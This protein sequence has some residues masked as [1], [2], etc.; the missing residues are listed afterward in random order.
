MARLI[1]VHG[2]FCSSSV[3]GSRVV[4]ELENL[5]HDVEILDLPSH[6]RDATPKSDVT[7]DLY[8]DAVTNHV[9]SKPEP[10]VLVGHSM[11]GLVIT[12]AADN[13][14]AAGGE[15]AGLIY[16]AAALPR[17]GKAQNDYTSLPE[18]AG[19]ELGGNLVLSDTKPTLATVPVEL[20]PR[21]LFND[22]P[23][24]VGLELGLTLE[25]QTVRVF[26]SPVHITDDRPIH[27]GYILCTNDRAIPP[28]LQRLM[29]TETPGV[30]IIELESD[31]SPFVSHPD[32]FLAAVGELLPK[33]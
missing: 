1:L 3:W 28:A 20:A 6:G 2:A 23:E 21:A 4:H 15:I 13:V 24:Q 31:H 32:E 7:L 26:F 29:A 18:G 25:S 8:A 33:D 16:V 22:L 12:Q 11:G 30:H 27:R 17:N 14:L 9:M 10:A 19:D 5:G